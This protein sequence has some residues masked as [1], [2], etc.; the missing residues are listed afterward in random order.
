MLL[1]RLGQE[2]TL[3]RPHASL[4]VQLRGTGRG[5]H[6]WVHARK[7]LAARSTARQQAGAIA[8]T[9]CVLRL[10]LCRLAKLRLLQRR[11]AKLRLCRL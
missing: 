6:A 11:L 9:A 7:G 4:G 2:G 3:S 1:V 5:M 8:C 10:R